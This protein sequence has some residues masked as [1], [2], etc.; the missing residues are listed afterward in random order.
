VF[1]FVPLPST[2]AP[3]GIV[4]GVPDPTCSWK[5]PEESAVLPLAAGLEYEELVVARLFTTTTWFPATDP[6][7]A[8]AVTMLEFEDVAAMD[9]NVPVGSLSAPK[10]VCSVERS[11]SKELMAVV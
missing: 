1:V 2:L 4:T 8:D 11:F 5:L 6:A 10:L 9:N 3:I 7:A